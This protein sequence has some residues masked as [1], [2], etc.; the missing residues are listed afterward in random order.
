MTHFDVHHIEDGDRFEGI[1]TSVA[2]AIIYANI[3]A[4][5]SIDFDAETSARLEIKAFELIVYCYALR[6]LN[7]LFLEWDAFSHRVLI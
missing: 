5:A 1:K 3:L 6:I 7:D 2:Q 4:I